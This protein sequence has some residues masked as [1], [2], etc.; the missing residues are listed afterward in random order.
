AQPNEP[1]TSFNVIGLN[2]YNGFNGLGNLV[3]FNGTGGIAIFG[4]PVSA[5]GD[6]NTGD[7]IL[8]NSVYLNGRNFMTAAS[9]PL[10]LLGIDMTNGSLFPTDD[11]FT[12]N[13]SKGHGAAN[14]PNNFQNFPVLSTVTQV[15]GGVQIAGTLTQAASPNTT[16]RIEFFASNADP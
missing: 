3:A 13:D 9:K 12:A 4:N 8:G 2:P 16:F 14:A 10:P 7:S 15:S 5:S 6:P 1:G 11:G